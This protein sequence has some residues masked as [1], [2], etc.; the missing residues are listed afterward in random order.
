MV[1]VFRSRLRDEAGAE[2]HELSA[3]MLELAQGMPGFVDY[4]SFTAEDGERVTVVT[5]ADAESQRAWREQTDH[6][7]AQQAGRD[8]FYSEYSIQVGEVSRVRQFPPPDE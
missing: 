4:K 1:T 8:R 7:A 5:F 6:S 3:A 2:F